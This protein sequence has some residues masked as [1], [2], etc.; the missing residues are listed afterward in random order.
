MAGA[1]MGHLSFERCA[2]WPLSR[3]NSSQFSGLRVVDVSQGVNQKDRTLT[4]AR[5]GCFWA[6]VVLF[7]QTNT[8][9]LAVGGWRL[10]VGGCPDPKCDDSRGAG[11]ARA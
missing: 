9:W 5:A 3:V 2:L 6:D 4:R 7:T 8:F 1:R 10:A 11:A